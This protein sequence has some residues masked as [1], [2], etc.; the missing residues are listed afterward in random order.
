MP[1]SLKSQSA[2]RVAYWLLLAMFLTTAALTM[3]HVSAGFFTN[4][5]ADLFVPA[6]MYIALRR[7]A[8]HHKSQN[9]LFRFLGRSPELA[10]GSLLVGSALSE[11][12]QIFWPRGFFAGTFDPLDLVAYASGLLVCYVAD[13]AQ[14]RRLTTV[15]HP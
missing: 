7:L 6:W 1:T 10:A 15:P 5:A 13:R 9:P 8:S 4:Y 12:S 2:W 14:L 11:V 3:N